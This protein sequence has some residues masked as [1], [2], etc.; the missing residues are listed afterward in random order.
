ME[1]IID[2]NTQA[3]DLIE[4]EINPHKLM[5]VISMLSSNR[6]DKPLY[7]SV[8]HLATAGGNVGRLFI[9]LDKCMIYSPITT[10]RIIGRNRPIGLQR[11][12]TTALNRINGQDTDIR[13]DNLYYRLALL[14]EKCLERGS[15]PFKDERGMSIPIYNCDC[16][17]EDPVGE[18]INMFKEIAVEQRAITS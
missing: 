9:A 7:E 4:N 1:D 10:S 6:S 16:L 18:I 14:L 17:I 5:R 12:K 11:A 3:L 8:K 13:P 2:L 15:L